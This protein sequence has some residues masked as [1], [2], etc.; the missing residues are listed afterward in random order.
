MNSSIF[1][2]SFRLWPKRYCS[3]CCS[4]WFKFG[5]CDPFQVGISVLS[6]RLWSFFFFFSTTHQYC[7]CPIFEFNYFSKEYPASLYWKITVRNKDLGTRCAHCYWGITASRPSQ[8]TKL[9]IYVGIQL[10]L[11]HTLYKYMYMHI[12]YTYFLICV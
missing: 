8:Q 7:L 1:V 4:T 2:L 12:L 3:F 10:S 5:H 6:T 9:E 11:M